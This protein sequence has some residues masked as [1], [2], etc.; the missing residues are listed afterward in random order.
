MD[1]YRQ[2]IRNDKEYTAVNKVLE[3]P[4]IE[5]KTIDNQQPPVLKRNVRYPNRGEIHFQRRNHSHPRCPWPLARQPYRGDYSIH[6]DWH[7]RLPHHRLTC[8]C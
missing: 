5:V 8:L 4:E 7:P 3:N 1:Q 6:S 2:A